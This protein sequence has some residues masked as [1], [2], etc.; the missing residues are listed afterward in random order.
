MSV[1]V[2]QT[3]SF[4]VNDT[5][6]AAY[7]IDIY[8]IGYYQGN[9][10][11]L[12]ATIP[13]SQT[14]AQV[15]PNPLYNSSTGMYDAGNWAV[16]ASWAVPSDATSGVY[17][18][19]LVRN[20]T[21]GMSQI[22]F[23]VRNDASHSDILFTTSDSTWQAYNDWGGNS[24][25]FGSGPGYQG[26]A[27][28]VSYNRPL[29]DRGDSVSNQF[30]YAEY[31]MIR[32]L[33]ANGYD[34]S[35]FTDVDADRSGSLI[36]NHKIDLSVGHDEYWSGNEFNNVMAARN[37][38]VNLAFFSGNEVFW[39]TYYAPSTDVSHT[40]DRTLVCYKETHQ[41]EI[42]D[43]NNPTTWTGTWADPTFSPP[44]D[45]GIGQNEL[46]GT[47]FTVNRGADPVGTPITV[48]GIDAN[49][50][51]W[52]NTAIAQLAPNQSKSI[53]D[54]VLGYEWDEDVDNG[55]RPA[56]LIDLS[57]TTQNVAEKFVDYGNIIVPSTATHSLTLYR[58][59]SGAL[60]FGAGTVQWSWGLDGDHDGGNSVADPNMQQA[61]VNLFAD[62]G[63]QPA[64]LQ[65]GLVA[66]TASTDHTP[67]TSVITSPTAGASLTA[68]SPVT[69]NGTATDASGGVVAGV[70]VSVDGGQTWHPAQGRA[71]WSY[72]WTP[73]VG[74]SI[75][76]KSRAVDDSANLETPSAGVTVT[77]T[78]PLPGS[79]TIWNPAAKPGLAS[80]D[81]FP[82]SGGVEVGVKFSSDVASYITGVRF[83][84]GF[85]NTG[86]H[87]AHLWTSTGTLL[88]SATFTAESPTGWQQVNFANRVAIAANTV[89]VVSYY[90][91]AGGYAVDTG[92]F[93]SQYNSGLLHVPVSGGV[94]SYGSVGVFPTNSFNA[95][96]Y[97]VDVVLASNTPP[98]VTAQTPAPGSTGVSTAT[99]V[100]AAFN[101]PVQAGTISF[102]LKDASGNTVNGS[103]SYNA[104]NYTATFT[105]SAVLAP[106]TQYT[107]VVS[108]AKDFSNNVMASSVSWSFTTAGPPQVTSETPASG[109]T[110]ISTLTSVTAAFNEAVQPGTISF[111]LKDGSGNVV[112]ATVTYDSGTNIATLTPSSALSTSATYT[113]TVSGAKDLFGD[114]M[115]AP[116][117]WSFTTS[118]TGSVTIWSSATTPAVAS[119]NDSS[120]VEVGVKFRSDVA[121]SVTGL[122]FYKGASNTGTHI[123]HLWSSTGTLLATATFS[124]ETTTGWQQVSFATP[125]A[126]SPNTTYVVSY[127]A[128][129]GGYAA[130]GGYFATVGTDNGPLHA[131]SNAAGGGDGVY[132]YGAGGGFPTNSYNA[133]NY[134]VDVVFTS[135]TPP[136]VTGETP[137]SGATGIATTTTVTATFSEAVQAGTISFVLKDGSGNV[138]P[139]TVTYSSG[140]NTATLTPNS[141]LSTYATYTATVSGAKGLFGNTMAS[142]VS[143]SFT[144]AGPPQVTSETPASGVTGIAT[145]TTV[146]ATFNEA[147]QPGTISFVLKDASNN[148]VPATV[149]YDSGTNIATLTPS[150]ALST[151]ATY[152]ATVSGAKDL[153]GDTMAA[154]V[155]WSFTTSPTGSVTIWSSATTPAVASANDSS[156][157]EV[158]VKFRSDV[159][160]SVTG[161][162]FYKGASNTGTHIGHLWSSTG[163][164][165]ATATFSG[166]TTTGWQQV[167]FATPVAISPNTTYVV[168]YYAPSGGYAADGGYFATVGT[169]NGPLHALSNAA[170]GGDGVYLYGAGGGFPTNSYNATNYWVDVVFTSNT[171]PAVTGETPA[172]GATGIATTTTV[173]ATFSEAVQAGTISFVLKDGSGNVV[174]ATVTYSSGTNTATLTPNSALS[175]YATY[176]ATVSGAKGL[177]GNTMAAP[178]TWSFTTL[179]PTTVWQQTTVSDFSAGAQNN[180]QVTN[181]SGGE[182]QLTQGFSDDFTG[183]SLSSASW[184][185]NSWASQGGGP[186]SVTTSNSILSVSGAEVL[187]TATYSDIP[188]EGR[189]SFGATPYQHFGLATDLASSSGNYWAMF[190]TMGTSNTLYARVNVNGATTDVSLG[191]L[192]S[193]FHLYEVQPTTGAFV[194]FIDGSQVAS[195]NATFPAGTPLRIAFSSFSGSPQPPLQADWVRLAGGTFTSSVF[196]AGRTATWGTASWTAN[197]PAGT[198]LIVETSSGNTATPDST[199][200][201]WTVVSNGGTVASPAARY[202]RYRVRLVTTDPTLTPVLDNIS[203]TWN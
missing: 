181:T 173:T 115:A 164:L 191:A 27:Y 139:A 35:Y 5:A 96:N 25:Y 48:P 142:P 165:L 108:G 67:P 185:T 167:S 74:G 102:V 4:K 187:S 49:L 91:P 112:P 157:V 169:D 196:D 183:T 148:V 107:A 136:A 118:P 99:T 126:I 149:T 140:T 72:T 98:T 172:S 159:A 73:T 38:G 180:T 182:I 203:F 93:N 21:G 201:P 104:T 190:S 186:T 147:V 133:T 150:S 123:G 154:P 50:R 179:G 16:S 198:T 61:T 47:F 95:S 166:E 97:W 36:L 178:V 111:V 7:E 145:L 134:W 94:Y 202:L 63:V 2:G 78:Q 121:G 177:F 12:V 22:L 42:L 9:G 137:A 65:P 131:L 135:N 92:Y 19:D 44:A 189:V 1:N 64:T 152:T 80:I 114:T 28:A 90:V 20:D 110:G 77:V 143:W 46:T 34:V 122:R 146:T 76:I 37:A 18:A 188:I 83:Y 117:T 60:I 200:S 29:N 8:R 86:T 3:V 58:A 30:F 156:A 174:P 105:P 175:T 116:V 120:A 101:E 11:R 170:G 161:L 24:L 26:A 153:F 71:S 59:S 52:R 138:V 82:S 141:A 33:E 41:N 162:R 158:G 14:L 163:T 113:A 100:T 13:S 87:V 155:T 88:A 40:P 130:D 128:P 144:T 193:G 54:Q 184:T 85:L 68:G 81:D 53:G 119:A 62:M 127:Y 32:W 151:S 192:P 51:F 171:P 129:S 66:A 56:G 176:T 89:Y 75:T 23:V 199:W 106:S 15:Q 55:F 6:I 84:K 79:V 160:G 70:E 194:F 168:S 57:S 31:P 195:I 197:V 17:L 109:A 69:I 43:P 39:K 125:V 45:G 124:G 103:L 10:A 132:L